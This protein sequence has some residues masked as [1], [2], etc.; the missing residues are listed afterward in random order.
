MHSTNTI[1]LNTRIVV[2]GSDGREKLARNGHGKS[3]E[4]ISG[5]LPSMQ[6][7]KTIREVFFLSFFF[8]GWFFSLP[9]SSNINFAADCTEKTAVVSAVEDHFT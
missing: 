2:F 7:V 3:V 1:L 4:K 8:W 9:C 6:A 5:D